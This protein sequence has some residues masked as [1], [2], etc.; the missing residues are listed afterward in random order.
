MNANTPYSLA[1]ATPARPPD[2][3]RD[4][5]LQHDGVSRQDAPGVGEM[6]CPN[7]GAPMPDLK[8]GHDTICSVCGY[9]DSC[10]Y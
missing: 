1:S 8:G 7:C 6:D 5:Q 4:Q 10:C 9:K 3:A 2:E